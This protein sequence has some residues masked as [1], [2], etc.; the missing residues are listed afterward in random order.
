MQYCGKF[1]MQKSAFKLM[2]KSTYV[3]I[4]QKNAILNRNEQTKWETLITQ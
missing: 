1:V 3:K 4:K 2:L